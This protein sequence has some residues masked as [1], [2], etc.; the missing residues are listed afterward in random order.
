MRTEDDVRAACRALE[1]DAPELADVLGSGRERTR[2]GHWLR[3]IMPVAATVVLVAGVAVGLAARPWAGEHHATPTAP[4]SPAGALSRVDFTMRDV[5][6]YTTVGYDTGALFQRAELTQIGG[7]LA[8]VTRYRPGAY[9]GATSGQPVAVGGQQGYIVADAHP[10]FVPYLATDPSVHRRAVVWQYAPGAW[11]MAEGTTGHSTAQIDAGNLSI[12][13]AVA[14]G[15]TPVRVPFKLGYLPAGLSG[16]SASTRP[17][18]Y[19]TTVPEGLFGAV[20]LKD[21]TPPASPLSNAPWASAISITASAYHVDFSDEDACAAHA[22]TF[23]VG[24]D[25]GCFI[26]DHG[27]TSG[28]LVDLRGHTVRM[29]ID[30]G[31]YRAYPDSALVHVLEQLAFAPNVNDPGTWFAGDTAVPH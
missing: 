22:R 7:S 29:L 10:T 24:G 4:S 25:R 21:G 8:N 23:T 11:A 27:A 17:V 5:D 20:S 12:A 2:G 31:H 19:G 13:R 6:G 16:E 1:D 28:L 15:T 18:S 26:T 30:A 3:A 14:P 9:D